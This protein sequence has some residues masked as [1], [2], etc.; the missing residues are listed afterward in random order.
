VDANWGK[1]KGLGDDKQLAKKIVFCFNYEAV[2][3][4]QYLALAT[5]STSLAKL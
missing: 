1:I 4:C 2:K 5:L 3:S